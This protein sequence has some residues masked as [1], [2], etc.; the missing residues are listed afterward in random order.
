MAEFVLS[1]ER[2][3]DAVN[4]IVQFLRDSGYEGSLEDGTGLNDVVVKPS[5]IIYELIAQSVEKAKAYQSLQKAFELKDV[6]GDDEYNNA[7]DGLLSNWFIT[8][9]DG[10]PSTG[11]IRMCF[12]KPQDYMYFPDGTVIGTVDGATLVADTDQVF[13]ETS[14]SYIL[15]TADNQNEYYVDVAVRTS[16]NSE[17]A[18]SSTSGSEISVSYN[19]IYYLR[20][21]IPGTFTP[22]TLVENSEDFIRRAEYAIT[23]RELIT[24][25][26]IHTVILDKFADVIRLYVARHGSR[27]QLRD[28]VEFQNITV[29]VGNKADI[30]LASQLTKQTMKVRAE[31]GVIDIEQLPSSV[32][33]VA[34]VEAKDSDGN[35]LPLNITCTESTWCSNG[36]LP[37]TLLVDSE[38]SG[39]VFLTMLTDTV[40][41][42][43]HEFVY[44]ENQR[45]TCYDPMVKHMFPLIMHINLDVA[46]LDKSVNSENDIKS[47]VI[48]Y[49]ASI[50]TNDEPWVASELVSAVHVACRNVK[51]ISLPL[52]CT[53]DI[54]DPLTQQTV[55]LE[56]GNRFT[57]GADFTATHS[58]QITDNTVQFYTD[59]D[60]I[61][62]TSDYSGS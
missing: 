12:L 5:A 54:Y 9:N 35:V 52:H 14:F 43:V 13:T 47:A 41:G 61:N 11:V 15:N 31:N 29:H 20:S 42:Q 34:Y 10:K 51:K 1:K 22:G 56:I 4:V 45:V 46:L 53:G 32:A 60:L 49:I 36:M 57:I 39:D 40:L 21:T 23:T 55:T 58:K 26:A 44:S 17:I 7:V 37:E 48:N 30:Y 8:R 38:Y 18:P 16:T 2:V 3:E 59:S 28:I 50:V 27:E 19:D 25:R 33:V 62:I 6:I 24:A